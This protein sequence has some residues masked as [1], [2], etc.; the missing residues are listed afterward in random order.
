VFRVAVPFAI[1]VN[2]L[3]ELDLIQNNNLLMTYFYV[4]IDM[5]GHVV[6]LQMKFPPFMCITFFFAWFILSCSLLDSLSP[7]DT[8]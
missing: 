3:F 2:V 5:D 1:R 7:I 6:N 4:Y 8:Y